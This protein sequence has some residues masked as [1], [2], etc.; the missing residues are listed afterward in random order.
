MINTSLRLTLNVV[1]CWLVFH[2]I[3]PEPTPTR[4][5]GV[6]NP[7]FTRAAA[8][9]ANNYPDHGWAIPECPD[10]YLE[11]VA[12]RELHVPVNRINDREAYPQSTM[13]NSSHSDS[14][15][16]EMSQGTPDIIPY[17]LPSHTQQPSQVERQISVEVH[18]CGQEDTKQQRA[19]SDLGDDKI[20][21]DS[22]CIHIDNI[23]D[24]P[25]NVHPLRTSAG[26]QSHSA[27]SPAVAHSSSYLDDDEIY[28]DNICID[29]N[30]IA[31][32]SDNVNP[33]RIPAEPNYFSLQSHSAPSA[34]ATQFSSD[35]EGDEI[36]D[37]IR[38]DCTNV[39][40]SVH[41]LPIPAS[42]QLLGLQSHSPPSQFNDD[43]HDYKQEDANLQCDNSDMG[44]DE[45]YDDNLRIDS[46]NIGH[47]TD[48]IPPLPIHALRHHLGLQSHSAQSQIDGD[49]HDYSQDDTK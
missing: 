18:S 25:D 35:V 37:D 36:Y 24:K 30:S 8:I 47:R 45:I 43:V 34:V 17:H 4:K 28:D 22:I 27:P 19:G 38:I 48:N 1:K 44:D 3:L 29:S 49:V 23:D 12:D 5:D 32:K 40:A 10:E 31:G 39:G 26:L 13:V 16:S 41:T 7:G 6:I 15:P 9:A 11:E 46:N 42:H 14:I 20:Y 2:P 33:T 21:D